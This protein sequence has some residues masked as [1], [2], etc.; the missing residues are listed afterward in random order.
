MILVLCKFYTTLLLYVVRVDD[1]EDDDD[2]DVDV[3]V[4]LIGMYMVFPP[5][6]LCLV[7]GFIYRLK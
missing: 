7:C 6:S 2:D 5:E 3:K 1:D 4:I